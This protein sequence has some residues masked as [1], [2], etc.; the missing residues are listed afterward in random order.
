MRIIYQEKQQQ[1]ESPPCDAE[2]GTNTPDYIQRVVNAICDDVINALNIEYD[3]R[4]IVV[5]LLRS[6]LL[7]KI[8]DHNDGYLKQYL[9]SQLDILAKSVRSALGVKD[10]VGVNYNY[11]THAKFSDILKAAVPPVPDGLEIEKRDHKQLR[12]FVHATLDEKLISK[13]G[14]DRLVKGGYVEKSNGWNFITK[15][16]VLSLIALRY[17]KIK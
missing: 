2:C 4:N 9:H 6:V 8:A 1:L 17:I 10:S 13:T 7:P 16:G 12:A 14:R 5:R 11:A 3:S 15:K